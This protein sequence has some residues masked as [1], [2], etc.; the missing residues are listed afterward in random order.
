MLFKILLF[1][2]YII[3]LQSNIIFA[4]ENSE[5][6][7]KIEICYNYGCY[8]KQNISIS[9]D[10]INHIQ[11]T[12]FDNNT[13]AEIER[14]NIIKALAFLYKIAGNQTPIFRDVAGNYND[15]ANGK[16]DCIDHS[17]NTF[18]FLQFLAKYNLLKFHKIG[19]IETRYFLHLIPSHYAVS[20]SEINANKIYIIDSWYANIF[21]DELPKIFDIISWKNDDIQLNNDYIY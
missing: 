7:E 12:I 19:Q 20:I 4:A 10:D 3:L 17:T 21:A 1:S 14:K 8:I 5:N 18:N 9:K 11:N 13:N 6:S 16:M 2:I 15:P